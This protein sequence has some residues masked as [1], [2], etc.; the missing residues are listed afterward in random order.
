MTLYYLDTET[1]S[2]DDDRLPWEVAY[3]KQGSPDMTVVHIE[4]GGY[5]RWSPGADA[6]N[7]RLERFGRDGIPMHE[8][9]AASVFEEEFR[10]AV[11]VGSNPTFDQRALANLLARQFRTPTWNH[12]TV[13]IPSLVS[14]HLHT[15]VYGLAGAAS[16]MGLDYNTTL[17]HT[18]SYDA[19]LGRVIYE[20]VMDQ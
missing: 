7:H 19:I 5:V 17:A 11:F 13:D 8:S 14:G 20:M 16:M 15:P 4:Y 3:Q 2:L 6:I 9:D 1:S 18:A 10:D 12:R